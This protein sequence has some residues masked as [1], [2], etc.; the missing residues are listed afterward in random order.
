MPSPRS[1]WGRANT[2]SIAATAAGF[3]ANYPGFS[4]HLVS[5]EG[6]IGN[7]LSNTGDVV[8]LSAPDGS[9][10]DAMSYGT[11]TD[12]FA[13]PCPDVPAGQSL[14][15]VPPVVRYRHRRGLGAAADPQP[16]RSGRCRDTH[17]HPTPTF[18]A[19][20]TATDM[21]SPTSTA[22]VAPVSTSTPTS[23]AGPF[24]TVR[25]NEILPRPEGHRLGWQRHRR[26]L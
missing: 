25:L 6:T 16:R 10:V 22:T 3:A 13:P 14:A 9:L 21:A 7:G 19:T 1:P 5:L 2:W 11:N 24:P 26:R 12:A 15:R 18:T 23:T 8:R 4:G 17:R 20:P